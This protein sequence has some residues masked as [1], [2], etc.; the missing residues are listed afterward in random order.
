MDKPSDQS[1]VSRTV[2]R[3]NFLNAAVGA[4]A[5]APSMFA[6]QLGTT[7][8]RFLTQEERNRM[9]PSQIIDESNGQ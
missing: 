4:C 6:W 3:R 8:D 5:T 1:L 2:K 7:R 9:T